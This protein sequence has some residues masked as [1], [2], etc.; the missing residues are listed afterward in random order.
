MRV[1]SGSP[2]QQLSPPSPPGLARTCLG[3]LAREFEMLQGAPHAPHSLAPL[4]SPGT[5]LALELAFIPWWG[6]MSGWARGC[7]VPLHHETEGWQSL[8]CGQIE[9][10]LEVSGRF[11]ILTL[12]NSLSRGKS[13]P[14][15][16]LPPQPPFTWS[17]MPQCKGDHHQVHG[18]RPFPRPTRLLAT[19]PTGPKSPRLLRSSPIKALYPPKTQAHTL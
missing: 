10:S 15:D 4:S 3:T 2:Q 9:G 1:L 13:S 16:S 7:L 8:L 19:N 17:R 11:P 6:G 12:V 18:R 5:M 14:Q